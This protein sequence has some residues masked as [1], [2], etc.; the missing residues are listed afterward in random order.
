MTLLSW[1]LNND[2]TGMLRNYEYLGLPNPMANPTTMLFLSEYK[3]WGDPEHR[4]QEAGAQAPP[5]HCSPRDRRHHGRTF[6]PIYKPVYFFQIYTTSR[7]EAHTQ[8]QPP[9]AGL[10]PHQP[11]PNIF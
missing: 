8:P 7:Y 2:V 4:G 10:C 9:A 11:H 5:P 6:I 1:A 3:R